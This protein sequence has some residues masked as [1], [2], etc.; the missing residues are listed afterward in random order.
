M[1]ADIPLTEKTFDLF[2][3]YHGTN[4][5]SGSMQF[6]GDLYRILQGKIEC[7]FNPVTNANGSFGD[8]PTVAS[9]S[10]LFL[11][12]ANDR[13]QLNDRQEVA[14]PGL[15]NEIEAFYGSVFHTKNW[16]GKARVFG[17]NGLSARKADRFH[18]IFNMTEH[19]CASD[20]GEKSALDKLFHWITSSL[21]LPENTFSVPQSAPEPAQ[22]KDAPREALSPEEEA[23]RFSAGFFHRGANALKGASAEEVTEELGKFS[24]LYRSITE[25]SALSHFNHI[26]VGDNVGEQLCGIILEECRKGKTRDVMKIKG[27]IGSY[28]NRLLQYIYLKIEKTQTDILPFYIDVSMYEK[29]Y[30]DR[31]NSRYE[32]V[33]AAVRDDFSLLRRLI[34]SNPDKIPLIFL[35]GIRD[36]S[37]GRNSL[38]SIIDSA[39]DGLTYKRVVSLDTDFTVNPKN[40][41]KMHPL[42]PSQFTYFVRIRSMQLYRREES[43]EFIKNCISVFHLSDV[44]NVSPDIIYDRLIQLDL[45]SLDAYWIVK[46]LT[47]L[48]AYILNEEMTV[49]DLYKAFCEQT[50]DSPS[51]LDSAAELAYD[52]EF[53]SLSFDESKFYFDVRWKLMRK[54]RSILEFLIAKHYVNRFAAL[55]ARGEYTEEQSLALKFFDMVLPKRI[56][57]FVVKMLNET[58]D[59]EEKVLTIAR[60][61]YHEMS[62][63]GKSELTFWMG[64]LKNHARREECITLL[65]KYYDEQVE[66]YRK[67][68]ND[69][70]KTNMS[71]RQEAFLLRGISVSLIYSGDK[72]V[73]HEYLDSLLDDKTANSINRGFH[74]EYYGDKLYIPNRAALDFEDDVRKG[75]ITCNT[76]CLSLEKRMSSFRFSYV[77]ILELMT[78]CSLLQA[79]LERYDMKDVFR[80][81]PYLGKCANYLDWM[82]SRRAIGEFPKAKEYFRWMKTQI[83]RPAEEFP[84]R[85]MR[86]G[87]DEL[88]NRLSTS[89]EVPRTG[90]VDRK[91]PHPENIVEHMYNCWL[92]ALLFLPDRYDG[93]PDYD[94][95]TVMRMLLIHD[96]G[97]RETGDI[98]RPQKMKNKEYY[99]EWEDSVMR[100]IFLHGSYPAAPDL[101]GYYDCW[102]EWYRQDSVNGKVAKD[103][104]NIQAIYQ[105]C[106]YY[107][108]HSDLIDTDDFYRWLAQIDEIETDL[109]HSVCKTIIMQNEDFRGILP[110]EFLR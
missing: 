6:A 11:L 68:K 45:I 61:Y 63:F 82:L 91:I 30:T 73:L 38:Y 104:D 58:D 31:K 101:T 89:P 93:Y 33:E 107:Q 10:R 56:T 52:Y 54:H 67:A 103:I 1:A 28:K 81:E 32:S 109:G 79:R 87:M 18:V 25:I 44:G 40:K 110:K 97:E 36:F 29:F 7:F 24:A 20:I 57:R 12:V 26:P 15:Y 60:N 105:M 100:A 3:A 19:F 66:A 78:L 42:A 9:H 94:K 5:E 53:G 90:W 80:V 41:I 14:S 39:L 35:D 69:A 8:T 59:Y 65:R 21:G 62:L 51:Q 16:R 22:E 85:G 13:I 75:E 71:V 4:D 102:D 77:S 47:L 108:Q 95:N 106:R 96:L 83:G 74:L 98:A 37:S 48:M 64:R 92:M 86:N 72:K 99:D 76:L 49:A 84:A 34:V 88:Y 23:L 27:P 46:L 17:L 2:I 50:L 70:E 55:P 43:I